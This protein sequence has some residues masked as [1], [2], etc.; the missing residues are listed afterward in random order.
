MIKHYKRK[1]QYRAAM[2]GGVSPDVI[3][4]YWRVA[5][6]RIATRGLL[7]LNRRSSFLQFLLSPRNQVAANAQFDMNAIKNSLERMQN[8]K[9]GYVVKGRY[10]DLFSEGERDEFITCPT[11]GSSKP[12]IDTQW[13]LDQ[14]TTSKRIEIDDAY[15]RCDT[16]AKADYMAEQIARMLQNA[17][18]NLQADVEKRL[19]AKDGNGDFVY[20][21]NYPE[22]NNIARP[23]GSE[24]LNLFR[25]PNLAYNQINPIAESIL[26]EDMDM[27]GLAGRQVYFGGSTLRRYLDLKAISGTGEDGYNASLLT[28]ISRAR[29]LQSDLMTPALTGFQDAMVALRPGALAFVSAPFFRGDFTHSFPNQDRRTVRDPYF[30]LEWDLIENWEYCGEEVKHFMQV[31]IVWGLIGYP[32]CLQGQAPYRRGVKD[33]FLYGVG[34]GDTP[35]CGL[36]GFAAN[37]PGSA[38]PWLAGCAPKEICPVPSCVAN[39]LLTPVLGSSGYSVVASVNG[40]APVGAVSATYT[41]AING[42]PVVGADTQTV[43]FPPSAINAGD[44]VSVLVEYFNASGGKICEADNTQDVFFPC[45]A[46][47]IRYNGDLYGNSGVIALGSIGASGVLA[48]TAALENVSALTC[49]TCGLTV[50]SFTSSGGTLTAPTAPFNIAAG[51]T[52]AFSIAAAGLAAGSYN[53]ALELASDGCEEGL[54]VN[55][56]FT[57]TP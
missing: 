45:G 9:L 54:K 37:T 55:V 21:G 51:G 20:I 25:D 5:T 47:R 52:Q 28:D 35:V 56:T 17:A 38:A 14:V 19:Y 36:P 48:F 2:A 3:A 6:A 34:C 31:R 10:Y 13:F 1:T 22:R 50:T 30:N 43:T 16:D 46:L 57:V 7:D 42:T 23:A 18:S 15:V 32:T 53:Y 40:F 44:V 29:F 33:V 11:S 4:N 12:A 8:G 24:T 39:V 41:W 27:A 26:N 49:S